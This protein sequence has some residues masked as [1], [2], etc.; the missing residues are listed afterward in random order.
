MLSWPKSLQKNIETFERGMPMDFLPLDWRNLKF[1][2][3]I[4]ESSGVEKL[5]RDYSE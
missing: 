4:A 5:I 3:D 1:K 2:M